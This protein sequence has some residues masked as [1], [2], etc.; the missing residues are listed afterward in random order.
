MSGYLKKIKLKIPF[1]N[2][3]VDINVDGKNLILTGGNGCGKTQLIEFIFEKLIDA[4]VNRNNRTVQQVQSDLTN[5]QRALS[6]IGP[7]DRSYQGYTNNIQG[8]Q[9]KLKELENPPLQI[10][11]LDDF[12][13]E[14]QNFTGILSIFE[15]MRKSEIIKPSSVTNINKLREQ[16]KN[17]SRQHN[18]KT[19]TSSIFEEFLVSNI[20][21]QAFS[22]STKINNDPEEAKRIE[23]WFKKLESDLQNLFEDPLLKLKFDSNSFIFK[24][25]QPNKEPYTLQTLSSGFSSIM[26]I[27]AD[28]ITKISL[29]AIDPE[30]LT[31]IVIIDEVDAHLHVSLQ[32]KIL[33]FLINSFPKVQF[34]VTTHSPFVVTSIDN[35]V[36]YDLSTCQQVE[37]LS[38][39]SY[40]AVLEGLF[41]VLPISTLLQNQIEELS[42]LLKISPIDVTKVEGL[43]NKLPKDKSVLDEESLYFVKSADIALSKAKRQLDV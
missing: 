20:A 39:Y 18:N 28:L 21:N 40:E 26:S 38:M 37:D 1:S 41:G 34:I 32:K 6:K 13:V 5:H 3:E 4:V 11:N 24:I 19:N 42:E 7:A 43:L 16:D 30:D 25:H 33:A 36:I 27:Y 22:E 23:K 35:A 15:A 10:D 8:F 31:G 2:K 17:I 14:Y 29:R 9:K 12:V